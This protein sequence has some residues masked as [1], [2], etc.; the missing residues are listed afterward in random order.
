MSG[1]G[2]CAA[3]VRLVTDMLDAKLTPD[4]FTY[5]AI[6]NACQ[7]TDEADLA[8]DVLRCANDTH[9]LALWSA[10]TARG[11]RFLGLRV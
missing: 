3:Q 11:L 2:R 10:A 5:A 8:F 9:S 7:R 6:L 4:E 1:E